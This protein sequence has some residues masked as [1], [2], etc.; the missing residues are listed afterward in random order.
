MSIMR[1]L[2][3]IVVVGIS[4]LSVQTPLGPD[5]ADRRERRAQAAMQALDRYLETWNSRDPRRW[6]ASLHFPHIRP[7]P[8]PFEL[9]TTPEEYAAGVDFQQ[10]LATGW[11]HSEWTTRRVVHVGFNKV[12]I[13]GA[14]QRYTAEG[15]PLTGSA[16]SY[17]VTNQGGR[18]GV[19]SRFAAGPTGI[20]AGEAATN[21]ADGRAAVEAYFRAWNSHDPQALSSAVHFPHVRI[22]G[23]GAVEVSMTAEAFLAGSEPGRQRTWHETRVDHAEVIQVSTNGVN[24]AVNYSRLGRAGDTLS[25]SEAIL[26]AVR[27]ENQ[28]KIQAVSTMG[29]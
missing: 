14:W 13:A 3:G 22:D 5:A 11:H 7:G 19:L 21:S 29:S 8:G 15:R 16:I 2:S 10:T 25:W 18:W 23:E 6:A 12:H 17:V 4:A 28:W 20:A 27:R 26:L 9:A 24:I 1:G